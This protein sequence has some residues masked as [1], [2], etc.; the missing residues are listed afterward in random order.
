MPSTKARTASSYAG[1]GL[2]HDVWTFASLVAFSAKATSRSGVI[3]HAPTIVSYSSSSKLRSG[4]AARR[5]RAVSSCHSST[6]VAHGPANSD[7]RW[8]RA[9]T[10]LLRF[11][12]CVDRV[13]MPHW[14]RNAARSLAWWKSA[15]VVPNVPG[16]PP[17]SLSDTSRWYR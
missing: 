12:S 1:S 13:S 5:Y 15:T 11:V 16:S 10:S 14:W 8:M 3:G 6:A 7:R 2:V 9:R 4:P 17:T